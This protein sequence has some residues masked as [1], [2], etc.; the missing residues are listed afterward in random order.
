M[1]PTPNDLRIAKLAE[2]FQHEMELAFFIVEIGM[3]KSEYESLT[4]TEKMFI[5]KRYEQKFINDITWLRNAVLNAVNNAL[6][7]KGKKFMELFPKAPK[8]ADKEYNENAIKTVLKLEKKNGK[9]WVERIYRA[10]EI[11]PLKKGGE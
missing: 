5:R 9:G 8:R 3:S 6:R 1:D 2:P 10:N 11:K 7:K 4:E